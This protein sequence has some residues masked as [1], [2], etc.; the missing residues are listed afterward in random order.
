MEAQ[1]LTISA[2]RIQSL[3]DPTSRLIFTVCCLLSSFAIAT[4]GTGRGLL[5]LTGPCSVLFCS[6]L[7]LPQILHLLCFV[8]VGLSNLTG[9]YPFSPD[10]LQPRAVP[11]WE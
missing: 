4:K 2:L 5:Y 9:I 6:A 10:H 7:I 3:V 1:A 8:L 11:P